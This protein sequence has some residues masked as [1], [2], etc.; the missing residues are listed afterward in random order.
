MLYVADIDAKSRF[1]SHV[2]VHGL[3]SAMSTIVTLS[4]VICIFIFIL[5]PILN[6][7]LV[8]ILGIFVVLS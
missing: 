1:R 6:L 5:S 4:V 8:V 7:F 3:G 2:F